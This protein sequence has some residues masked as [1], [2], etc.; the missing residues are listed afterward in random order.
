[1]QV[2]IITTEPKKL[3]EFI[4]YADG[5]YDDNG[6]DKKGGSSI[7]PQVTTLVVPGHYFSRIS[8][9][10]FRGETI[11]IPKNLKRVYDFTDS[12]TNNLALQ[13]YLPSKKW[14]VNDNNGVIASNDPSAMIDTQF[15]ASGKNVI[16]YNI[17]L[18]IPLEIINDSSDPQLINLNGLGSFAYQ[19]I[20]INDPEENQFD[21]TIE[22]EIFAFKNV[23]IFN[24]RNEVA[25]AYPGIFNNV[26]FY[27]TGKTVSVIPD[28]DNIPDNNKYIIAD[29]PYT[30]DL[31]GLDYPIKQ[32]MSYEWGFDLRPELIKLPEYEKVEI[33]KIVNQKTE[34]IESNITQGMLPKF[35]QKVDKTELDSLLS[36]K[37]NKN[38]ILSEDVMDRKIN[39]KIN[40]KTKDSLKISDLDKAQKDNDEKN[41]QNL[42]KLA[43]EINDQ[44]GDKIEKAIKESVNSR[45]LTSEVNKSLNKMDPKM[46]CEAEL[47]NDDKGDVVLKMNKC[48][49]S[50][51]QENETKKRNLSKFETKTST[52]N[53]IPGLKAKAKK[54]KNLHKR[55]ISNN[56]DGFF[57]KVTRVLANNTDNVTPL[58]ADKFSNSVV[59]VKV[60]IPSITSDP[61]WEGKAAFWTLVGLGGGYAIKKVYEWAKSNCLQRNAD[62]KR[63]ILPQTDNDKEIKDY[64]I[65]PMSSKINNARLTLPKFSKLNDN[66]SN[67]PLV[68]IG[69]QSCDNDRTK[70]SKINT[71][72]ELLKNSITNKELE[73]GKNIISIV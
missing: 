11:E 5:Q 8:K 23:E 38:E 26:D 31:G 40:E 17:A 36:Q 42:K 49:V 39:E 72:V 33:E 32:T 62:T 46:E 9:L 65:D 24:S 48:K 56:A 71:K 13:Y 25:V 69:S 16:Y 35:D 14:L 59:K 12:G 29:N 37:A 7:T 45:D 10:K 64:N 54:I 70:Y 67:I 28:N 15:S 63:S 73:K 55:E 68:N 6:S 20:K 22:Y 18:N 52:A 34:N 44:N 47:N 51:T 41:S 4:T 60:N 21:L 2:P 61:N 27:N 43:D 53:T 66:I 19:T 30:N 57:T 1:M 3:K 50:F 58:N